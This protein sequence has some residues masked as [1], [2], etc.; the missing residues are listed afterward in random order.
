MLPLSP[1]ILKNGC[2]NH[3]STGTPSSSETTVEKK[4][5]NKRKET[6]EKFKNV[7]SSCMSV[8]SRALRLDTI[9][10]LVAHVNLRR[11][12]ALPTA[13]AMLVYVGDPNRERI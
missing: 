3:T 1:V 9:R 2:T 12:L 5:T 13:N 7:Q 10:D 8:P 4:K 11:A 6:K